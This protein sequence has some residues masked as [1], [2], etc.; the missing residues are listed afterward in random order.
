MKQE[1]K[2]TEEQLKPILEFKQKF[3]ASRKKSVPEV[4]AA[5]EVQEPEVE[6][7]VQKKVDSPVGQVP[8]HSGEGVETTISFGCP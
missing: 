7:T 5:Q 4:P 2:H 1:A 6:K 3:L 8:R